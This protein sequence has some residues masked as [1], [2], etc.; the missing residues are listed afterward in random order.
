MKFLSLVAKI[1]VWLSKS[2]NSNNK[3]FLSLCVGVTVHVTCNF[4]CYIANFRIPP[5]IKSKYIRL[6]YVFFIFVGEVVMLQFISSILLLKD[7]FE[8]LNEELLSVF[9]CPDELTLN[10]RESGTESRKPN[11]VTGLTNDTNKQEPSNY[12]TTINEQN[13]NA[14]DTHFNDLPFDESWHKKMR[15]LRLRGIYNLL[16]DAAELVLSIYQVQFLVTLIQIF[17]ETSACLCGTFKH[18][19][20]LLTCQLNDQSQWQILSMIL[21]WGTVNITKLTAIATRCQGATQKANHTTV[22][23]HKLLL[24]RSLHPE[25]KAELQ[26]FSQQ[27]IHRKLQFIACGFFPIDCTL[28]CSMA[29]AVT[30]Y[31]TILLQHSGKHIDDFILLCNRTFLRDV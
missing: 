19:T 26:L 3:M 22:L 21:I 14:L 2:N 6:I 15:V 17:V 29:G 9:G 12:A 31:F 20:K 11:S 10:K 4:V 7:R 5:H 13:L 1:D 8:V 18:V 30:T 27:M 28:L 16:C 24:L 23:V 25:V